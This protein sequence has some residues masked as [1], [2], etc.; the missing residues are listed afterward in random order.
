MPARPKNKLIE[1][2]ESFQN[3]LEVAATGGRFGEPD[4]ARVRSELMEHPDVAGRLPSWVRTCRTS[5]QFWQFIKAKFATYAERRSF[6]WDEFRPIL[7]H[8]ERGHAPSDN[9]LSEVLEE[10]DW[11]HVQAAW[12]KALERRQADPDGA[13]TAASTLMETTCKHILDDQKVAY[14]PKADL[15]DLYKATAKSLNLAP[16]QHTEQVFKQIL[17]GCHSVVQGLGSIRSKIGDAHGKVRKQLSAQ[18][19]HAELAV[20]LAG[21]MATFLI[22]TLNHLRAMKP[23]S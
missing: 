19:R 9:S 21:A 1:L 6:I 16:E 4:Y 8:L 22:E 17:G 2:V 18:P 14:D 7:E 11:E 12:K 10:F 20:N 5:G 15:P 23:R 13:V 3:A